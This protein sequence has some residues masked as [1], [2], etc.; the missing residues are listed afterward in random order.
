MVIDLQL[1]GITLI[2]SIMEKLIIKG[3]IV[4]CID[5]LQHR[6]K[7]LLQIPNKTKIVEVDLNSLSKE[8]L[9]NILNTSISYYFEEDYI[10][11]TIDLTAEEKIQKEEEVKN[12]I[13]YDISRLKKWCESSEEN[14]QQILNY[15]KVKNII[16]E[17]FN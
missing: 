9:I 16:V 8:D 7:Y 4:D 10:Y 6:R 17:G 14:K 12:G 15:L 2:N 1:I 11:Y 13:K 5:M 3:A